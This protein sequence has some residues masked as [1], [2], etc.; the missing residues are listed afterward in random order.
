[1]IKTMKPKWKGA[2]IKIHNVLVL[3]MEMENLSYK[4]QLAKEKLFCQKLHNLHLKKR[5]RQDIWEARF[6]NRWLEHN[7]IVMYE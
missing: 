5:P 1:M 6:G 2:S 7:S 4:Q 3:K